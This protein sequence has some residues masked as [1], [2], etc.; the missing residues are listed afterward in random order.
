MKKE[1]IDGKKHEKKFKG[2]T[3]ELNTVSEWLAAQKGAK[4]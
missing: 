1:S 4:K 2:N 3:E